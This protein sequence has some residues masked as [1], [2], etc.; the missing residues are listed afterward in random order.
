[1]DLFG[2]IKWKIL[3]NNN[4]N[5]SYNRYKFSSKCIRYNSPNSKYSSR[6]LKNN[7]HHYLV[8]N[9]TSRS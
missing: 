2:I 8:N 3:M 7:N 9:W 4:P 1:M 5:N 6:S